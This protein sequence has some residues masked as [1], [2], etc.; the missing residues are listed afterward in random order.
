M[1]K[2]QTDVVVM[3][4]GMS[5]IC[6]ADAVLAQGK[7]VMVFEKKPYQGGTV[8][9]CPI[10]FVSIPD[11]E[12]YQDRVF[13]LI[14]DYTNYNADPAV[15]RTF[16]RNSWRT[17]EYIERMKVRM[18]PVQNVPIDEIGDPKYADG[19]PPA[20]MAYGEF[21]MAQGQGKGHGGALLCLRGKK[22]IEKR[23]GIYMLDTPVTD[24]IQDENGKIT[25]VIAV[26]N[27]TGE[28]IEVECRALIICSGGIMADR[29]MMKE[30]TGFTYTDYNCSGDGN[31]LFNCFPN[32]GQT[33]DGQKLA[34]KLGGEET[35]IAVTG[36]NLVPGPGIVASSPWIVY[37]EM[38]TLQ[39]QPY[40]WVNRNGERF[41]DESISNNHMAISMAIRNQP[42]R[43]SYF[44]IDEDTRQR[45]ENVGIDYMYFMFPIEKFHDIPGQICH[46]RDDLG[47]KHVFM[48]DTIEDLCR[49][50]GIDEEGMK[51]TLERYNRFCDQKHDDD[52]A[53]NPQYLYPV[54]K[55]PFYA[56]R[57]FCA[58]YNTIGGIKIN[59]RSQVIN[60]EGKP[61]QG[62]F[63]AG[64][65][66][67]TSLY[68]NPPTGASA[69]AYFAMPLGF[70][71]G[72][73]A[74]AYIDE[75]ENK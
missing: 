12:D 55:G 43:V 54:R 70:A 18:I 21:F 56:L 72:D 36:H 52:F 32:S 74:C 51:K 58:G 25:G 59:G 75:E 14:Y 34:W 38:R 29:K 65:A 71:S 63:A 24:V 42:G 3:G 39:E 8:G 17:K 23:G 20:V 5:G 44:V 19:F 41:A 50:A 10:A 73:S 26:E 53:K 9:N 7:K 33:G 30:K 27:K 69:G 6:A 15:I 4:S 68:G 66:V 11:D 46:L 47:N 45:L 13:K 37:N 22:D 28:R 60:T 16:V 57:V 2:F 49:A 1:K 31:V 62:L 40:L 61:I 48:E 35:A 64:D 67:Q